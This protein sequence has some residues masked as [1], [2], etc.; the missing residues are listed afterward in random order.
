MPEILPCALQKQH[1][2]SASLPLQTRSEPLLNT[3][4]RIQEQHGPLSECCPCLRDSTGEHSGDHLRAQNALLDHDY[5]RTISFTEFFYCKR[6]TRLAFEATSEVYAEKEVREVDENGRR[7]VTDVVY[8]SRA[9]HTIMCRIEV[10]RT[11]RTDISSREACHYLE[12]RCDHLLESIHRSN[13]TRISVRCETGTISLDRCEL[14]AREREKEE[15]R[16]KQRYEQ[17]QR[18]REQAVI[19]RVEAER[20]RLEDVERVRLEEVERERN[21]L[22]MERQ[23]KDAEWAQKRAAEAEWSESSMR[24]GFVVRVSATGAH[25]MTQAEI[26]QKRNERMS[27]ESAKRALKRS[28][29]KSS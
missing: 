15:K 17:Q 4:R 1:A 10:W 16:H 2:A 5:T 18:E 23:R 21:E 20:V 19:V 28:R 25:T 24:R 26:E 9:D 3:S 27:R 8:R 13:T 11:H 22:L 14:C 12:V 29:R 7:F 6:H